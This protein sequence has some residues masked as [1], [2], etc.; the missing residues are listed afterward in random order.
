M[1]LFERFATQ[2]I[3]LQVFMIAFGSLVVLCAPFQ[4]NLPSEQIESAPR[5]GRWL[6]RTDQP[7]LHRRSGWF[8][9]CTAVAIITLKL[10]N[11]D[12]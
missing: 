9:I 12:A 2:G 6:L 3:Y 11:G 7:R 4:R 5:W 8:T 10:L 1:D